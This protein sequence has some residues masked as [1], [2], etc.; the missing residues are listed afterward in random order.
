MGA[1]T[2]G[3]AL[4]A[5]VERR[6]GSNCTEST[7]D[8]V[9]LEAN[10]LAVA[11]RLA[12]AKGALLCIW[13][14]DLLVATCTAFLSAQRCG[15]VPYVDWACNGNRKRER[16]HSISKTDVLAHCII[17]RASVSFCLCV[18]RSRVFLL[19]GSECTHHCERDS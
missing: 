3:E 12:L 4:S 18:C 8:L 19:R 10:Q 17:A 11:A 6:I 9:A 16:K 14:I 15:V 1:S 7:V 13:A 2:A 5:V